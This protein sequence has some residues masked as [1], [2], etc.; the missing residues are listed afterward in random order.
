MTEHQRMVKIYEECF[1][2]NSAN[3]SKKDIVEFINYFFGDLSCLSKDGLIKVVDVI[4]E[5]LK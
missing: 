3:Q 4:I 2:G 1:G 5:E